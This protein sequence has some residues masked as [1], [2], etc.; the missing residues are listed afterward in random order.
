MKGLL[1][2]VLAVFGATSALAVEKITETTVLNRGTDVATLRQAI[3]QPD[4]IKPVKSSAGTAEKW[5]YRRELDTVYLPVKIAALGVG[6]ANA[7]TVVPNFRMMRV[8]TF[9][10]TELRIVDGKFE[11]ARQWTDRDEEYV[12]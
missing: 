8:K 3:G 9:A 2:F 10:V 12:E 7:K 5:Y 1:P 11:S 4:E 6:A